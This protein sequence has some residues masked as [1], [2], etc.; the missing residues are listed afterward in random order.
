MT[1]NC[2]ELESEVREEIRAGN[3]PG[4]DP[5]DTAMLFDLID[6]LRATLTDLRA[7]HVC[8]DQ[9]RIDTLLALSIPCDES[10]EPGVFECRLERQC[11]GCLRRSEVAHVIRTHIEICIEKA[12][13]GSYVDPF[14]VPPLYADADR[15]AAITTDYHQ[16]QSQLRELAA[17]ITCL[18]CKSETLAISQVSGWAAGH[19]DDQVSMLIK[20]REEQLVKNKMLV[21]ALEHCREVCRQPTE[22]RTPMDVRSVVEKRVAKIVD[23]VLE[24]VTK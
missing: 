11:A 18:P 19:Y 23:D 16:L 21:S 6:A 13:P 1:Y 24:I 22:M 15:L 5:H 7:G 3:E 10:A 9:D 14:D 2:Y 17:K 20:L 8:S 4:L 12:N